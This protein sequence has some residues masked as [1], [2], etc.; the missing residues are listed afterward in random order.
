MYTFT[1]VYWRFLEESQRKSNT[2]RTLLLLCI[3]VFSFGVVQAQD[4]TGAD[5]T[6]LAGTQGFRGHEKKDRLLPVVDQL[7][8]PLVLFA[9]GGGGRPGDTDTPF[10]A[11]L[12]LHSFAWMGRLSGSV[13]SVAIVSGR[14]FA[15]NAALAGV[16]DV[17]TATPDANLGRAGAAMIEGGGLGHYGPEDIGPVDV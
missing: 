15:G 11:G 4:C 7:H 1:W 8:V 10:L 5:Y 6:V 17:I 14:C 3:T 12:Q 13:P 2:M 9:E 16:C